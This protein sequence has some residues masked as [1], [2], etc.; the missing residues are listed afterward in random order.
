MRTIATCSE[1]VDALN[2]HIIGQ[3]DAKRALAVAL[4]DRWRRKQIPD[5]D[6]RAEVFP[7]NI[8]MSGPTGSGKTECAR[9]LSKIVEAPFVRC[10]ATRFTEVGIVGSTPD[11]MI[12]DL[13]DEAI[14]M[15][16]ARARKE[17]E[18]ESSEMAREKV[19][20]YLVQQAQRELD[21]TKSV[22]VDE[23]VSQSNSSSRLD[24]VVKML[25]TLS[26][27]DIKRALHLM[28][29]VLGKEVAQNLPKDTETLMQ[30]V[31]Q[32]R[33]MPPDVLKQEIERMMQLFP[34]ISDSVL[35]KLNELNKNTNKQPEAQTTANEAD[36]ERQ[37]E[38][39]RAQLLAGSLDQ[40]KVEVRVQP[41]RNEQ[42]RGGGDEMS[43][44]HESLK[45]LMS[46]MQ[47]GRDKPQRRKMTVAEWLPIL[48]VEMSD[49]LI[50]MDAVV[51]KGLERCQQDGI[52]FID[53]IDKLAGNKGD[54]S[55]WQKGDGVQ[56][57]LLGLLEG[58][59]VR[60]R[61]GVVSTEHIMFI[62]AGA[63]HQSKP[64]DL[65]PELQGRLAVRVVLKPLNMSD[66][67]NI[68]TS[69]KHNMLAQQ[70]AL[71][72]TEGVLLE[73]T[74]CGATAIA[75]AASDANASMEN[76]GARRLRT[77]ISKVMEDLKFTADKHKGPVCIDAEYVDS[78]LSSLVEK[79]DLSR[80]V[81]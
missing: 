81:L 3:H 35:E 29:N 18:V 62:A 43:D 38:A 66:M 36:T 57:E 63:F 79:S 16:Q 41:L 69:T 7:N 39:M 71:L 53:E 15:E 20:D 49:M 10:E 9:R 74:E 28:P 73:F 17:V 40:V 27:D 60:T 42:L 12:K 6:L 26:D 72:A 77:I 8:L 45:S 55:Q 47:P 54:K 67:L 4:R 1:I 19:V 44:M 46:V 75:Q 25:H 51:S 13:A 70:V 56:K 14:L 37:R 48:R 21:T 50:D 80:Y 65:L 58:T 2:E 24:D 33:A 61:H 22:A 32:M 30:M 31:R 11:I 76:I 52:V 68:V 64:S 34:Q 78:A 5:P 23:S 59:M